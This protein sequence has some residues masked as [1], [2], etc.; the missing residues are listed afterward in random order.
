MKILFL[1]V[2]TEGSTNNSQRDCLR[3]LGHKV[4]EFSYRSINNFNRVLSRVEEDYDI[5]FIFYYS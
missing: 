3:K 2:F 5:L 1:G 4:D